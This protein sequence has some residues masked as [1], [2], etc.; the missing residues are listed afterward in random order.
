MEKL[1]EQI[2]SIIEESE[3]GYMEKLYEQ[4]DEGLK[5]RTTPSI[6]RSFSSFSMII[7]QGTLFECSGCDNWQ[8]GGSAS[9]TEDLPW[10]NKKVLFLY[11]LLSPRP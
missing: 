2:G 11:K 1:S 5:G 7:L 8:L 3:P 6:E 10:K 9:D 4:L